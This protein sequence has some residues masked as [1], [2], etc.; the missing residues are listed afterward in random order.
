M[1]SKE[2]G[3]YIKEKDEYNLVTSDDVTYNKTEAILLSRESPDDLRAIHKA[4]RLFDG[5]YCEPP[6]NPE[7]WNTE[8][9]AVTALWKS[10]LHGPPKRRKRPQSRPDYHHGIQCSLDI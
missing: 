4:K 7:A 10:R 3:V 8:S 2:L 9:A 5:V 1:Y 6:R